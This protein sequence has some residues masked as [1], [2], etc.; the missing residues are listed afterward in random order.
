MFTTFVLSH[1]HLYP[2]AGSVA[3]WG[4]QF[5]MPE[6]PTMTP[7]FRLTDD[8]T[9]NQHRSVSPTGE[10]LWLTPRPCGVVYGTLRYRYWV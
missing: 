1:P 2:V 3:Q 5:Q 9:P 7:E 8:L 10:I 4:R 6:V